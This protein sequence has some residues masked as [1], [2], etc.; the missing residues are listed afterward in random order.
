MSKATRCCTKLSRRAAIAASLASFAVPAAPAAPVDPIFTLIEQHV[1]AYGELVALMAEQDRANEALQQADPAA[2][3]ALEARLNA[4]CDAEWPLGQR[5][6]AAADAIAATAPATLAGVTA[7]LRYV[8]TVFERDD[9]P[10]YEDDGYR[11]L[12]HTTEQAVA[13]WTAR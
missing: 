12:L 6:R 9:F 1:R 10:L 3:P 11:V 4:L 2:Q 13:A 8:R 5:E 7:L